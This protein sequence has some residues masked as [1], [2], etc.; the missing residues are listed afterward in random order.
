MEHHQGFTWKLVKSEE[1]HPRPTFKSRESSLRRCEHSR[2]A[3][4]AVAE[5]ALTIALV[6]RQARMLYCSTSYS[7]AD[8]PQGA[9]KI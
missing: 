6:I 4:Y 2:L 9:F 8:F 3:L 5:H 7:I 1:Y